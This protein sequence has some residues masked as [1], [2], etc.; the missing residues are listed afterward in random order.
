MQLYVEVLARGCLDPKQNIDKYCSNHFFP[1]S[2]LISIDEAVNQR[3]YRGF[4]ECRIR[5]FVPYLDV[6]FTTVKFVI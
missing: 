3:K 6:V 2:F 4:T 1:G 5:I